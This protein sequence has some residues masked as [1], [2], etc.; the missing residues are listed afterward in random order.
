MADGNWHAGARTVYEQQV[1]LMLGDRMKTGQD[2][3]DKTEAGGDIGLLH[4]PGPGY[5]VHR[6]VCPSLFKLLQP[7]EAELVC[8]RQEVDPRSK[9]PPVQARQKLQHFCGVSTGAKYNSQAGILGL[10]P[11]PFTPGLQLGAC[12]ADPG[13]EAGD[14]ASQEPGDAVHVF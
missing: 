5:P 4:L 12:G 14:E 10:F 13:S 7:G 8:G 1:H 6:V 11:L 2:S 9:D 3:P